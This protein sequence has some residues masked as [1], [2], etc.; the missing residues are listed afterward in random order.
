MCVLVREW[1]P[2]ERD[3]VAVEEAFPFMGR[4]IR[5]CGKLGVSS[6]VDPMDCYFTIVDVAE[7]VTIY[8]EAKG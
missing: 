2:D 5:Y 3:I 1:V 8:A 4:L 7:A 6:D